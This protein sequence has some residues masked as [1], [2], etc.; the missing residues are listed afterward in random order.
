[1]EVHDHAPA[2]SPDGRAVV[3]MQ[4]IRGRKVE[5]AVAR[6]ALGEHFWLPRGAHETRMLRT[7]KN[8]RK[9]IEVIVPQN[10]RN[11]KGKEILPTR[12]EKHGFPM[13]QSGSETSPK[14]SS[15]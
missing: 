3:F 1:M 4:A 14:G 2:V 12:F 11:T 5:C 9:R 7:F 8:G 13:V 15:D 6:D 10:G